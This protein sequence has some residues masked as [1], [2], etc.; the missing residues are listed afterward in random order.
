MFYVEKVEN[1]RV[2]VKDTSDGVVEVYSVDKLNKIV[3]SSKVSILGRKM[4]VIEK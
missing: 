3:Q 2:A 4:V 1:G